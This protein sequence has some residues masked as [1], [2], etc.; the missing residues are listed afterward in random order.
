MLFQY[1]INLDLHTTSTYI[2]CG[3]ASVTILTYFTVMT[4]LCLLYTHIEQ[5][6]R[7]RYYI[8]QLVE[9]RW[10]VWPKAK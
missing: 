1:K 6:E 10:N 4:R 8:I 2:S 3:E 7:V 9:F 5:A